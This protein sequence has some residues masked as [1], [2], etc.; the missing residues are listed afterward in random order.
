MKHILLAPLFALATITSAQA[1]DKMSIHI[2]RDNLNSASGV[3]QTLQLINRHVE[4]FCAAPGTRGLGV[5]MQVKA[6]ESD[7]M[8]K[9]VNAIGHPNLSAAFANGALRVA[10]RAD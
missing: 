6:C 7:M 10:K 4:R 9:A 5:Q 1:A 2:D 8:T 3:Q